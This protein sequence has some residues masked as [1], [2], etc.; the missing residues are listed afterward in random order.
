VLARTNLA[1]KLLFNYFL[2]MDKTKFLYF[3]ACFLVF[4]GLLMLVGHDAVHEV[5]ELIT[6]Y[7]EEGSVASML[8][9]SLPGVLPTIVGVLLMEHAN[10]EEKRKLGKK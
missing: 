1:K 8:A 9:H 2:I 10:R 4:A 3:S 6:G 7:H 5:I